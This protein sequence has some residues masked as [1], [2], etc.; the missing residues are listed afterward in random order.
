MELYSFSWHW[1]GED[2]IWAQ[3]IV[4]AGTYSVSLVAHIVKILPAMQEDA[5]AA[6]LIPGSGRFLGEGNGYP[7]QYFCL[8][9]SIDRLSP[10][11]SQRVR[12]DWGTN[13]FTF[14]S[15]LQLCMYL[16][17]KMTSKLQNL[18]LRDVIVNRSLKK[19]KE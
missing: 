8:E 17:K 4:Y 6:A 13:T 16:K 14:H 5:G 10:W 7:L 1:L 9:N 19:K 15:D 2:W 12:H 18:F 3:W 11:D